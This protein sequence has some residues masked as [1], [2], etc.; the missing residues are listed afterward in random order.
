[1][2][3]TTKYKI[4]TKYNYKVRLNKYNNCVAGT[5]IPKDKGQKQREQKANNDPHQK[6]KV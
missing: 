6:T 4:R 1:M 5:N 3:I 2:Q